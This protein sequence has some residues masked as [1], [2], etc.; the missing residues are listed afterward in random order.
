MQLEFVFFIIFI[1]NIYFLVI[2][3]QLYINF[4][5]RLYNLDICHECSLV[6]QIV[7]I[8]HLGFLFPPFSDKSLELD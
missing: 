4:S 6:L 8:P 2:L 5:T 1:L 7:F 3:L